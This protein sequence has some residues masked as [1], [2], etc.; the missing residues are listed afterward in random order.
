MFKTAIKRAFKSIALASTIIYGAIVAPEIHNHYLRWEV[1]E[2]VVQVLS[3]S[4]DGGGTGFAVKGESGKEYIMTNRHVCEAQSNGTIR[5]KPAGSFP[6]YR[7]VVF[8]DSVHDLCLIEGVQ[9]LA[10]LSIGSNQEKGDHLYVVG[11]PGLR[12]LTTSQGEYIGRAKVD[13][14]YDVAKREQCPGQVIE[15]PFFL[16][17]MYGVEFLCMRS[18]DSLATNAVIYPGNSGSPVVNKWGNLIGVAFA[19]S[20]QQERDNYLVPLSYIKAVLKKF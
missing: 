2:S 7:R 14:P 8:M 11:H 18:Y 19:G 20:T 13:L 17:F 9:G 10:P 16:R 1:G 12:Q 4:S 3:M 5:V 15:L 6:V